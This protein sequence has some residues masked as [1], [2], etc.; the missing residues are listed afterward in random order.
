MLRLPI[1]MDHHATTPVDP[2]VLEVMLPFFTQLFG[3]A[4]SKD[5][6]FSARFRRSARTWVVAVR[7]E[8]RGGGSRS[9]VSSYYKTH[10]VWLRRQEGHLPDPPGFACDGLRCIIR[11]P[12]PRCAHTAR[13]R[14]PVTLARHRRIACQRCWATRHADRQCVGHQLTRDE[15]ELG[16]D[17]ALRGG[18]GRDASPCASRDSAISARATSGSTF[19]SRC[20]RMRSVTFQRLELGAQRRWIVVK[21]F[22]KIMICG[23]TAVD[24]FLMIVVVGHRCIHRSQ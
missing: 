3:N 21:G 17:D 12:A 20:R 15:L 8:V 9:S 19:S 11:D 23:D 16:A 10:R 22:G 13:R 2:R 6:E 18:V 1:Y 5:H 14:L 7:A 4:A 24:L